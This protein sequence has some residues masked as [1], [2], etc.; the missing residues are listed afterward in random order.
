[1]NKNRFRHL[2][3]IDSNTRPWILKKRPCKDS[4]LRRLIKKGYFPNKDLPSLPDPLE[5]A[6]QIYSKLYGE[7]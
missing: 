1:M 6:K 5:V 3:W 2:T 4:T 7:E